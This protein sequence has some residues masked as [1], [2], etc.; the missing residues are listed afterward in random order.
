[1]IRL[2]LNLFRRRRVTG[3]TRADIQREWLRTHVMPEYKWQ[4]PTRRDR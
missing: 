1:M 3:P 2:L 4:W